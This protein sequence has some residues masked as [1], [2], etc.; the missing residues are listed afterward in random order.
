MTRRRSLFLLA[1]PALAQSSRER[2]K[3]VLDG[4]LEALGGE[5]FL[6]MRDRV[7]S[8]RAYTFYH[9]RLAGLSR[10]TIH[11]RYLTA[12]STPEPG[13]VYVRERQTLG[14]N[15][16]YGVL[17]DEEKGYSMTLRGASPLPPDTIARYQDT[18]RRNIFYFLR[19][20]F[21]EPGLILEY[22]AAEVFENQ[23]VDV[24]DVTDSENNAATYYIH[25]STRLPVR[26][27]FYRRDKERVRHEEISLYSKF[28]DVGGG[29]QWPFAIMR[30]RDGEKIYE[31]FSEDV[32]IN[33]DL[34][35]EL[36]IL[37]ASMKITPLK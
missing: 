15:Q 32:K 23:P 22:R 29:V 5:R 36:F 37:S 11:T 24:I 2:A 10:A 28:R 12:S 9:G 8:G 1:V 19:Q 17:F 25:Q 27:V 4:C 30:S 35:D 18:T 26:Q 6:R 20:R 33:Q 7:E 13:K 31:I 21:H 3:K 34:S 16:D 14:K